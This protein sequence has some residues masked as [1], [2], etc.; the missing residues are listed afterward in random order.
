VSGAI[1]AGGRA[2]RFGGRDKSSLVVEGRR[3]VERQLGAL[4]AITSEV[5]VVGGAPGP[6]AGLG[7]TVVPDVR[8]GSGPLGGLY[9]ALTHARAPLVLVLACDLPMVDARF[10]AHLSRSIGDAEVCVP[11]DARGWHPLCACYATRCL[12]AIA[13]RLEAGR[14]KVSDA[15]AD[16][17][18]V[19]VGP[20]EL[21]RLDP[22][23]LLLSNV[24]SAD[25][26]A[27][28]IRPR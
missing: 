2:R 8:P 10:L 15:L 23:G 22:S 16:L 13:A 12:P 24:N 26:Y 5:F 18:R 28:L 21:A 7:V 6:F 4:A 11:R 1:L 25:D 17:R 19:E 20:D 27:A 14:L 3:I 9:T